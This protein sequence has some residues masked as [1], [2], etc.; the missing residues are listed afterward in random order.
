LHVQT[1]EQNDCTG[2]VWQPQRGYQ[3]CLMF[4]RRPR[5][6]SLIK[7]MLTEH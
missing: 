1:G 5:Y 3:G 7:V 6:I 4:P 2:V